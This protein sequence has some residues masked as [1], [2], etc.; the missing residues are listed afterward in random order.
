MARQMETAGFLGGTYIGNQLGLTVESPTILEPS[1]L[2]SGKIAGKMPMGWWVVG[3]NVFLHA[4]TAF[5]TIVAAS[6]HFKDGVASEH[7]TKTHD[8]DYVST[9]CVV[10]IAGEVLAVLFY[11][12]WYGCVPHSFSNPIP[13][14][15]GGGLF[16]AVF[17]CTLKLT[18]FLEIGGMKI[19]DKNANDTMHKEGSE[20]A[21]V[22]LYLQCFVMA[23][24]L[25]TG[26]SGTYVKVLSMIPDNGNSGGS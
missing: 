25:F 26:Q 11:V 22:A 9:W 2:A 10:M 24:I 15:L 14:V 1:P 20:W 5:V 18:Y 3:F 19:D 7:L 4:V 8:E 12:V 23:S 6:M 13:A 17:V 21:A 16:F